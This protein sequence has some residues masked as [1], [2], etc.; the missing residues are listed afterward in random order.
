MDR[1]R[2]TLIAAS[3]IVAGV[4]VVLT[5]QA[6]PTP[7]AQGSVAPQGM[8]CPLARAPY[9]S[10]TPLIDLLLNPETKAVIAVIAKHGIVLATGHVSAQE[11][12]MLLREGRRQRAGATPARCLR[13]HASRE[14]HLRARATVRARRNPQKAATSFGDRMRRAD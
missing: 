13:A 6:P 11:A 3:L 5:Q 2:L 12:L 1:N 8:D 7:G 4:G 9:S 14:A 10:Q